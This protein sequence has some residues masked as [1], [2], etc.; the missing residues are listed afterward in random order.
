MTAMR[1]DAPSQELETL[2]VGLEQDE[3]AAS[4]PPDESF[5]SPLPTSHDDL[6]WLDTPSSTAFPL[7]HDSNQAFQP[8]DVMNLDNTMQPV[9]TEFDEHFPPDIKTDRFMQ[10][11]PSFKEAACTQI[12]GGVSPAIILSM[13]GLELDLFFRDR[14]LSDPHTISTWVCELA[15]SH[16]LLPSSRFNSEYASMA[17][18]WKPHA[19][20]TAAPSVFSIHLKTL[21]TSLHASRSPRGCCS[22]CAPFRMINPQITMR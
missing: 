2:L 9:P 4:L 20:H 17:P 15:K 13:A 6:N 11:I 5:K 1:N 8:Y 14:I 22:P 12:D 18:V 19:H 7:S 10:V 3:D 16:T 21:A